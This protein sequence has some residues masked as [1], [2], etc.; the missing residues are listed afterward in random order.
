MLCIT[1]PRETVYCWLGACFPKGRMPNGQSIATVAI[2][3]CTI[4]TTNPPSSVKISYAGGNAAFILPA[5]ER[6][7]KQNLVWSK[8]D[9]VLTDKFSE[10]A[11]L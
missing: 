2:Y 8:P 3:Q 1:I 10:T 9:T 11:H 7:A 6:Y 4:T 5:L